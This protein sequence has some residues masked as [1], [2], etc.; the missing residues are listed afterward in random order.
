MQLPGA[1]RYYTHME[2]HTSTPNEDIILAREFQK[3]L[4]DP[5][6]KNGVIDQDK[7]IKWS[8][9]IKWDVHEYIM[10]KTATT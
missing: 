1:E 2:I 5:K 9:Q 6:R 8:I 4:S 7:Y 3:C 10:Y